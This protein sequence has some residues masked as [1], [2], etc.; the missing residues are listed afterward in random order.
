MGAV[1]AQVAFVGG[2]GVIE[3]GTTLHPEGQPAADHPNPPD[4][5][6]RDRARAADRHVIFD[7]ADAVVVQEAGDDFLR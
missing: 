1:L 7:L 2:A 5:R 4:Q 3:G 6:V